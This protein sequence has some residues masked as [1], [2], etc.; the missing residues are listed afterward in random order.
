M[1]VIKKRT[2]VEY[3]TKNPDEMPPLY[4]L[5]REIDP[6]E[7]RVCD[8][9]SSMTDRYAINIY[10]EMIRPINRLIAVE[11]KKYV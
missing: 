6:V 5:R 9:I 7:R 4:N 1:R 3:Y 10:K 8:Y 11:V 2:L